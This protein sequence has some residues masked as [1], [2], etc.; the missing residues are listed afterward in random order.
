MVKKSPFPILAAIILLALPSTLRP[1]TFDPAATP[2]PPAAWGIDG[3]ISV[4][5]KDPAEFAG[6]VDLLNASG[7]RW[8]R[9]RHM[10]ENEAR[11]A[12]LVAERDAGLHTS[13][14]ASTPG[15]P[16]PALAG[17]QLN[18]DLLAVYRAAYRQAKG[19]AGVTPVWELQNEPDMGY[20]KDLPERFTAFA[21]AM[22]LGL[23]DGA[24]AAGHP[25]TVL[26]GAVGLPP[27]PW[28]ESATAN[29]FYAYA[30]AANMHFY[31]LAPELRGAIAAHRAFIRE[32]VSL[33][34][35][36]PRAAGRLAAHE[37]GWQ[38]PHP[39]HRKRPA[40]LNLRPAALPI[41]ITE[42][43]IKLVS[44]ENFHDPERRAA[45]RD[46]TVET[47]L[48]AWREPD[49]AVFMPFI[50]VWKKDG[51]TMT[52]SPTEH[53]PAWTAYE[54]LT[55]ELTWPADR[56]MTRPPINPPRLILQWLPDAPLR[57]EEGT[58]ESD[59]G[60][61][62]GDGQSSVDWPRS[63]NVGGTDAGALRAAAETKRG[64]GSE[65]A[66]YDSPAKPVRT[67][68]VAGT[69]RFTEGG[70]IT[71][72]V[73][74]Y[75]LGDLE[76]R[77]RVRWVDGAA[78]TARV[79]PQAEPNLNLNPELKLD[80]DG[81][82]VAVV[83]PPMGMVEVPVVFTPRTQRG[84]FREEWRAEFVPTDG[85]GETWPVVFGLERLPV[86][87]DFDLTPLPVAPAPS[88]EWKGFAMEPEVVS[89]VSGPWRGRN[90]V[91]IVSA[92]DEAVAGVFKVIAPQT[93]PMQ[94][95][96]VAVRL[97]GLPEDGMLLV[98]ADQPFVPWRRVR[99]DLFDDRGQRFTQWENGGMDYHG[100]GSEMWLSLRDFHIYFWGVTTADYRFDPKRIVEMQLRFYLYDPEDEMSV[101]V[102]LATPR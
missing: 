68:K 60:R 80:D 74:I 66:R 94:P 45:Q 98:R 18:E 44:E 76:R 43:G 26:A 37:H 46:F 71:G 101:T 85:A 28:L 11:K 54:R 63:A 78:F 8:V 42:C 65:P 47:A 89:S 2:L 70:P 27:G 29:G 100:D 35:R 3:C 56:V 52:T 102:D 69:Y 48:T 73:R 34:D 81:G 53:F 10:L 25:T 6:Y 23:K 77:G 61:K 30:D 96:S 59:G 7:I 32:H 5:V 22:Y 67:H 9:E 93:H 16:K 13:V 84:Y 40:P 1:A 91:E 79:A 31:G 99:V 58:R 92:S 88:A 86:V 50:L 51:H 20:I 87:S 17:N 39:T 83:V 24:R 33:A 55:R 14:F 82:D 41:W 64:E 97:R 57:V 15:L 95:P 21:K 12:R 19:A 90:G 75:N 4:H 62:P 49:V 36:E 38:A 72:S